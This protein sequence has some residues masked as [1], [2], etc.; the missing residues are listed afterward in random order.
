MPCAPSPAPPLRGVHGVYHAVDG[1]VAHRHAAG[2]GV[3]S[4]GDRPARDR[5][6]LQEGVL[7]DR[8][9]EE[10]SGE[11]RAVPVVGNDRDSGELA[12]AWRQLELP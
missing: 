3:G 7:L 9:L 10:G 11:D 5:P 6:P 1:G 12:V 4:V 2:G 8:P